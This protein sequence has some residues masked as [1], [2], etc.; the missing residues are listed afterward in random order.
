M[1]IADYIRSRGL[2]VAHVSQKM[3]VTRQAIGQYGK[4]YGHIPTARSLERVAKAMT[5]LGAPTT[6][7]DLVAAMYRED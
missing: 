1:K 7:V 4:E 3:G 6:V 5:E 2:I